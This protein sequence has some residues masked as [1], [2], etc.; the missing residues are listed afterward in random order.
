[1]TNVDWKMITI[2]MCCGR[3][4]YSKNQ[5]QLCFSGQRTNFSLILTFLP[6]SFD[7]PLPLCRHNS[8]KQTCINTFSWQQQYLAYTSIKNGE[9]SSP[10]TPSIF[11]FSS[12]S[13]PRHLNDSAPLQY[14][15]SQTPIKNNEMAIFTACYLKTIHITQGAPGRDWGGAKQK[16]TIA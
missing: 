8:V 7:A 2:S 13:L 12:L 5:T 14:S 1:M 16:A 10:C 6:R 4:G 3:L 11:S 9:V 15:P